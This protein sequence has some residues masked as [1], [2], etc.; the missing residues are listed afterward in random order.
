MGIYDRDYYR[1]SSGSLFDAWGR[2]GTTVWLIVITCAV[3]LAQVISRDIAGGRIGEDP[4]SAF[5]IYDPRL[6][7]GGEVWRLLTS[8][9][10]HGGLLHLAF[11]M[12]VLYWAGT[13]ME[14]HYGSRE[15]LVFYLAAAL[16]IGLVRF[17]VQMVGLAPMA[18]ALGSSGPVTAVLVLF[19]F[20]YPRQ[21][22]LL[23]FVIPMPV[24]MLVVV[25]VAMDALGAFGIGDRG[26][27]YVAHLAGA[28]FGLL[29]YQW[30]GRLTDLLPGWPSRTRRARPR[31]R[32]VPP[33]PEEAPEPVGAAVEVPPRAAESADESF[34][35][36]VDR[37]L[38][39]VSKYG[40]ESLTPEEREILFRASEL[41]KKK[42]K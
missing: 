33:D 39:K 6:V 18:L 31:L 11:N 13:R 22:V 34:E 27:G 41:Y 3:F 28:L 19:A 5:G 4:V 17:T 42:R 21:Q 1:E 29:Y 32:V 15:F 10:L 16:F 30:G 40:Q 14:G 12:L 2:Q 37:V 38:E 9:F 35:A 23:F 24:W 25:Y 20:H 7:L 36:K 8:H 26:V